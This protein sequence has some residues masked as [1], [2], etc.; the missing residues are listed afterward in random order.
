MMKYKSKWGVNDVVSFQVSCEAA[1]NKGG[2]FKYFK[3]DIKQI[4]IQQHQT[5]VAEFLNDS[6]LV[7]KGGTEGEEKT[8]L[9]AFNSTVQVVK[10]STEY[11]AVMGRS[12]VGIYYNCTLLTEANNRFSAKFNNRSSE[13]L[14]K[15]MVL[16]QLHASEDV[17]NSFNGLYYKKNKNWEKY[18]EQIFMELKICHDIIGE[19]YN[20]MSM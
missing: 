4:I 10:F 15:D 12:C 3:K 19:H 17:M 11:C 1:V 13:P 18:G 8:A 6:D 9:G 20:D 5:F 14:T 2:Y 16:E 7:I